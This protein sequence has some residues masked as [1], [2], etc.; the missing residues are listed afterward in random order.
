MGKRR[1]DPRLRAPGALCTFLQT[2]GA[3]GA[4]LLVAACLLEQYRA[5]HLYHAVKSQQDLD[6]RW[7]VA[8]G[9]RILQVSEH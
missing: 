3:I 4:F 9:P 8:Y 7:A 1:A 5:D 6:S 2:P